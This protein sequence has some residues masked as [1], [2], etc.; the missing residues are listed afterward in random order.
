[1]KAEYDN[2]LY[3]ITSVTDEVPEYEYKW[4]KY[5]WKLFMEVA[6]D[7]GKK[8]SEDVINDPNQEHF[9]DQL[10]GRNTLGSSTDPDDPNASKPE[11]GYSLD[12]SSTIDELKK[13]VLFRP[14]EV[15]KCVEDITN[16]PANYA[17]GNLLGQW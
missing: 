8:V 5:F 16:D 7:D 15:D 13:D 3:S 1:L 11:T 2:K 12:V 6:I 17:C 9:I 4:R 10:L 14:P